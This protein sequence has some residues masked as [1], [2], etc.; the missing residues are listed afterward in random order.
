MHHRTTEKT[1]HQNRGV[2]RTAGSERV[3]APAGGGLSARDLGVSAD[4]RNGDLYILCYI[5]PNQCIDPK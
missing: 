1:H 2:L 5:Y 3:L 4:Y